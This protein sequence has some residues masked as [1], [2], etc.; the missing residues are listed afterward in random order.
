MENNLDDLHSFLLCR[1]DW[2]IIIDSLLESASDR[3]ATADKLSR[4]STYGA[5]VYDSALKAR[6][7]AE[8]I[9]FHLPE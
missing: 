2:Q 4:D 7:I 6:A 5:I 9:E 3:F 8:Y 1:D